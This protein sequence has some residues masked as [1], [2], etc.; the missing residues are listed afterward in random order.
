[1]LEASGSLRTWRLAVPPLQGQLV[2]ATGIGDHRLAYLHYEGPVSGGRG[3]VRRWDGGNFE[4]V[5]QNER[6]VVVRLAGVKLQGRLG[7][8]LQQGAE[9]EARWEPQST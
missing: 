5:E 2:P 7:L 8:I 6:L 4:W 3:Q 9:W 1:M